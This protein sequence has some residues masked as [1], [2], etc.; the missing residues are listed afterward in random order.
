MP[1]AVLVLTLLAFAYGVFAY[2]QFRTPA[3]AGG[4]LVA[5]ALAAYF[6]LASPEDSRSTSRIPLADITLDEVAVQ[7]TVRGATVT[8]RVRNASTRY[9]LRE[10]ML[11]VRLHDCPT[12]EPASAPAAAPESCP[13]I[14]EGTSLTRPDVPAGETRAFSTHFSLAG[15]T[16]ATGTLRWELAVTETRATTH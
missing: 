7:Q 10:M 2:P 16:P 14:G 6:F 8:G 13:V 11:Q 3:L 15:V 12:S 4:A 9:H 1:I 5:A